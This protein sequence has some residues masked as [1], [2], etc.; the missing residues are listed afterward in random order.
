MLIWLCALK[1]EAKPLVDHYRLRRDTDNGPFR[2]YRGEQTACVVSGVGQRAMRTA[3]EWSA[4]LAQPGAPVVRINLG[5][6]GHAELDIGTLRLAESFG[7][8]DSTTAL[9]NALPVT[10]AID[11]LPLISY[12]QPQEL[13]PEHAMI[14]MEAYGFAVSAQLLADP[15]WRQSLKVISDNAGKPAT[16][17]KNAVSNLLAA[18]M[19][20]IDRFARDMLTEA[21]SRH[22]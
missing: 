2:L 3:T 1:C 18:Q 14:D 8:A 21:E 19:D 12:D 7:R 4:W 22:A 13:Y 10:T 17:D 11:S 5:I 15:K 20:N 9:A 16:R 6:A